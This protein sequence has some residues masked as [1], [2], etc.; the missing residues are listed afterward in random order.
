[1]HKERLGNAL[2]ALDIL[3]RADST[4]FAT[5][6]G[7]SFFGGGA[8]KTWIVTLNGGPKGKKKV[9]V[10][11]TSAGEAK[12]KAESA[13]AGFLAN[14]MSPKNDAVRSDSSDDVF[15]LM[16]DGNMYDEYDTRASAQRDLDGLKLKFPR[17]RFSIVT[18]PKGRN[19][20]V[21]PRDGKENMSWAVHCTVGGKRGP[22]ATTVGGERKKFVVNAS[23]KDTAMA[24]VNRLTNGTV[25]EWGTIRPAT[26]SDGSR[27]DAVRSDA[28]WE[29]FGKSK[30]IFK[31]KMPNGDVKEMPDIEARTIDEADGMA[32]TAAAKLGGKVW[33]IAWRQSRNEW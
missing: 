29:Q 33:T 14:E 18:P 21:N 15:F 17:S 3:A 5:G 27:N 20:A 32:K 30:F 7:D 1:M 24:A 11:A 12:Q 19:D 16:Q 10:Q 13:N 2:A 28:S 22:N 6:R 8:A 31:V 25:M 4:A 23:S 26:A 9:E